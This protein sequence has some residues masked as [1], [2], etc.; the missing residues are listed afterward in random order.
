VQTV[1]K[2]EPIAAISTWG[3][4]H[5]FID[6]ID[7]LQQVQPLPADFPFLESIHRQQD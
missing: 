3:Y 5:S 6:E 4:W 2:L 7:K 1:A